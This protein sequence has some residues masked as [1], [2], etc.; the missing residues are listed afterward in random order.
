MEMKK[1]KS[2]MERG[3]EEK[4]NKRELEKEKRKENK[5]KQKM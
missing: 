4:V 2:R 1:I 5:K 3:K